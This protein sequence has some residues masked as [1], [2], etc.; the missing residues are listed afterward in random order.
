VVVP[1]LLVELGG[2]DEPVLP[3]GADVWGD[4]WLEMPEELRG[5]SLTDALSGD[6][7]ELKATGEKTNRAGESAGAGL[8]LARLLARFPASLL[9]GSRADGGDS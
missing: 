3:V 7:H 6:V 8:P 2:W 5:I 4:T 9:S 1:R